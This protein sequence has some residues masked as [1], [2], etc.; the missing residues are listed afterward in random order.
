MSKDKKKQINL[1][2]EISIPKINKISIDIDEYPKFCFKY[3]S[4]VSFKKCKN[5]Q[6]FIDFL[7]RLQKLSELSWKEIRKSHR[8]SFG[9]EKIPIKKIKPKKLPSIITPDVTHLHVFR[10]NGDKHVF[11]GLNLGNDF[12]IF[13]I[14]AKFGDIYDHK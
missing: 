12:L 10:A 8:H 4:D 5:Y 7:N 3:L 14:E 11:V 9:M 13:F 1:I 6:F 2:R